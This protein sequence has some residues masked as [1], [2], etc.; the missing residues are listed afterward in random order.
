M[1]RDIGHGRTLKA[2]QH[3]GVLAVVVL[4]GGQVLGQGTASGEPAKAPDAAKNR[5]AYNL[6]V[7]GYIIP[8][9]QSYVDPVFTADRN[10]LHL[11]ARYNYENLETGSLWA[12]YNFSA[13]KK[14]VLDV[15]PMIGGVFGRAN[16][17]APGC[18]ASLTYKKIELS[19]SNEYVFDT[20]HKSGN[21]YYSWPQLTYSPMDWF[22]VGLVA[23]RTKAFH[24]SLDTQRGFL[25][26]VSHK[27]WEFTTYIFNAGFTDPTVVLEAGVSF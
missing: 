16:G 15:T 23:Q 1:S 18:E 21:F 26:G 20:T 13:G 22:R 5:W 14:L 4:L 12:G 25:V 2:M 7:D 17:I 8:H 10:W 24:T 11:E 3:L 6:T 19:I 9:S 27:K